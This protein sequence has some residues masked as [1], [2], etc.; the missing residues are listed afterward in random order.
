VTWDPRALP[1]QAGRTFVVTGGGA[2]LGY[3]VS[4]QLAVAGARVVIAARSAERAQLGIDSI[5]SR[6]PG[7]EVLFVPF[8]LTDLASARE[9]AERIRELGPIAG[10]MNNA[11]LV[12]APRR[13]QTTRD[14]FEL[15]VGGNFL[16]H[17]ALTALVFPALA[18]G[19]RVVGM[20]SDS[21]RMVRLDADDLYSE[22][23][24]APFRAYAFSKHATHGFAFELDRRLR[25]AGDSRGALLAHPG[26]ATS[27]YA[28]R[29]PGI[30]GREPGML[31][32][33]EAATGWVGQG[34]DHG[35][36]PAVRALTD[37]DAV[38]GQFFGPRGILAGRPVLTT[39]VRSSSSP[40]FGARLWADAEQKTRIHF[41]L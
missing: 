21:T 4:E 18:P 29:R 8:D 14:G 33:G 22:R 13:R 32:F 38:S 30:T 9:A 2:G 24:Y 20:G 6:V 19:A 35:A 12:I 25:A 10:L 28:E 17:F 23:R 5:R 15:V 41:P 37:P 16:G 7:A 31:R 3:F 26:Y 34:K 36:W 39:P 1:S 27:A 40:A 11:G